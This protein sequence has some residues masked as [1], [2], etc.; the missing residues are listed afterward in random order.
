MVKRRPH[1]ELYEP[2]IAFDQNRID[3]R[4]GKEA[5]DVR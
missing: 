3:S 4:A 2:A 1:Q 5:T